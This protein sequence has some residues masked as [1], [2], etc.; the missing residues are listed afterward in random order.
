M[1]RRL[2][3][4]CLAIGVALSWA[5]AAGA[6]PLDLPAAKEQ[7]LVGERPDGLVAAVPGNPS[8]AVRGLVERVNR[9]R[10][11]RY[12]EVAQKTGTSLEAVQARAG[13][14]IISRLPEGQYFMDAAGDWRQR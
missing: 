5:P 11:A 1:T 10:R 4:L 14:Q 8:E 13:K 9:E 6:Q 12:E 3:L 7:G 2:F